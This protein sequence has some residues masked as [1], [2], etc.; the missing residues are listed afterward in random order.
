MAVK[1]KLIG[2]FN[3][4]AA[5]P[6]LFLGSGFSRRYLGL[7]DWKGL[8]TRFC[9]AGKPFEYYLASA[10]GNY[11]KIASLLAKDFNEYW[12][13]APEYKASVERYKSKIVD[14]TSALRIEIANYLSTL[15]QD[16]AK[17]SDY[18]HEVELLAN[19]NVDGVITT[20]WDMFIEQLF[21][22]YTT[23]VGQEELLFS[24][25]QEIG[26]IYK[27]H[28]CSTN[29]NSLVL[30]DS[31]YDD[32][33]EKNTYLAA[34]L[35]TLFVEHPI[36]FIGYSI[37][38]ENISSLL[39]AISNCIGRDNIEKLRQNLIFVQ[40][41]DEGEEPSTSDTYLSI[42]GIQIPLTLVK[43]DDF[44][45]VYEAMDATKR[46]IP[47]RVLRY[48]KEQL[49]ELVQSS[50]PEKKICVVDIDEIESKD[51][52]EFLVGVGVAS[53]DPV[54][55]S[56]VGYEQ[57][58]VSNLYR[59]ILHDDGDYDC[60]QVL[61]HVAPRALKSSPNVPVFKYLKQL[62]IEDQATYEASS[63]TLNKAINRD[64]KKLGVESYKKSFF[65]SYRHSSLQD[66]IDKC[67][68]ENASA[69]I[70][71]LSADKVDLDLL[72]RFLVDNEDKL[73]YKVSSYASN[74]KKLVC[75]Y[76]RMK[77]GWK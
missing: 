16:K 10:D 38:D 59:D 55:P 44:S 73:D 32:F 47:A 6:F 5:G 70:P 7:E 56:S 66:I 74:F 29:A 3:S 57:V 15:N 30:T 28:G 72:H 64:F 12:W 36:V 49:Y 33:N 24:N 19:L 11:P 1:E 20:N 41:L 40:R 22:D 60:E 67:T 77:W 69:Y 14:Q 53:S 31:D 8:L 23:Y 52:V 18:Q 76:D 26:E 51:D 17:Q 27:I 13:S 50:E 34:K 75:L 45:P 21:P 68:A 63:Y 43:T 58:C 39:K 35:I 71:Y 61:M 65:R 25:P 2:I 37:S 46:K 62:G 54:G 9:V 42:D 4:K 48:C